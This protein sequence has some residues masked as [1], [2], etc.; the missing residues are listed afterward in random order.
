MEVKFDGKVL[1]I[2]SFLSNEECQELK[3][4]AIKSQSQFVQGISR[5]SNGEIIRTDTRLTNRMSENIEYPE[6]VYNIQSRLRIL[7]GLE[8]A[9]LI[10]GHGKDGVVVS[11]TKNGGDVYKH[12]DPNMNLSLSCLRLNV[13]VSKSET[14]GIIHVNDKTYNPNV[15]DLMCYLV[16]EYEHMVET[17]NGNELRIMFM[18]GFLV[19]YKEWESGKY[20]DKVRFLN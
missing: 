4:W 15:G 20:F 12:K 13:L 14:G 17:C 5:N 10:E 1:I 7:F 16:S 6:L 18:F 8:E 2:D 19:N 9:G 3:S 11:I